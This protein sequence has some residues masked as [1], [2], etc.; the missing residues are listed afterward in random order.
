MIMEI[1]SLIAQAAQSGAQSIPYT[2]EAIGGLALGFVIWFAKN[3][4][5]DGKQDRA[6]AREDRIAMNAQ[7]LEDR[8]VMQAVIDRNTDAHIRSNVIMSRVE[9]RMDREDKRVDREE[10]V[11]KQH[12]V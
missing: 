6:L 12:E 10:K 7:A 4:H 2:G 9:E 8:K 1:I 3:L 11:R 5:A